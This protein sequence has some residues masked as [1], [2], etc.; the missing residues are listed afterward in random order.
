MKKKLIPLFL[1]C[2][3]AMVLASGG[4]YKPE[5]ADI[6]L[7]S[8]QSLRHGAKLFVNYCMSCHSASYM[9]YSRMGRDLG[10]TDKEVEQN[11]MFVANFDKEEAGEAKKVGDLMTVAMQKK[12]A[13]AY[14]G[15][16]VPD[17]TVIA[18]ARG[19][20]WL[21]TYLTTFYVDESRPFGVNNAIFPNVGMPHVLW[22]LQG[23]KKKVV[24]KKKD[25]RGHE[26]EHIK[27]ETI[28]EGTMSDVEFKRAMNDLVNFLV[29]MGEPIK[30]ERQRIGIFVM[31]FLIFMFFLAYL[32][33]KEY[34]T[35]IH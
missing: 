7:E 28:T 33:K 22:Q 5:K 24:E 14:F 32:L 15:T 31:F 35:D 11:L 16:A 27:F 26:V 1:L 9:R 21:Y 8:K 13:K 25:G 4:A 3:P 34:W 20:D 29:Y 23:L 6:N 19:A 12:D 17:L 2:F 18:R 30:L 10:L